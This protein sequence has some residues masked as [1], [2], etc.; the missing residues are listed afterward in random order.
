MK[1]I[2]NA[3][4]LD[5]KT[6]E[7]SLKNIYFNQKITGISSLF[8]PGKFDEIIDLEGK[9][10]IPGCIDPHVHFNDP[11]FTHHENF[12]TG[13]AAAAAGGVTTVIDMPCTSI[14]AVTN[15]KNLHEKLAVIN[16]KALID[17]ALWGGIRKEDYPYENNQIIELWNEGVVGFKI[18][19]ISGMKDFQALTYEEIEYVFYKFPDLLFAFHAEDKNT[20]EENLN[21][22]K[23]EDLKTWHKFPEIRSISA[24][25]TAVKKI[26]DLLKNN[27]VHFVHIS[28]KKAAETIIAAK[29]QYYNLSLETCPHYLHFTCKD[30][31]RLQ[32]KLKTTPPVK[33][34]QDKEFLINSLING[35]LDFIA[36]DHAGC[37]YQTEKQL[38]DFS[39]IYSGIPGIQLSIP[40]LFSEFYLKEKISLPRMI[41]ITSENQA[42]RYGLYPR[43]GSLQIGSDADFTVIDL[44]KKFKVDEKKLLSIG[45]YSPFHN[46]IFNC[47]VAYT[48]VRG[49]II[50]NS[51]QGIVS[52]KG[53]GKWIRRK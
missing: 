7:T 26:I 5:E 30:F 29:K 23:E 22:L 17:F 13:T 24:E 43:K 20:I 36:T 44:N 52:A 42:K 34:E 50:Y 32:G 19:T 10:L 25:F 28:S 48:I 37:D 49:R 45:K 51:E 11:G 33:Y 41:Q 15:K 31:T 3:M 9:L 35:D 53:Y 6:L 38:S 39:K 4:I 18:Y 40:Y 8:N 21:S 1:L 46:E 12:F 16:S 47:S 2:K 27:K 14:P